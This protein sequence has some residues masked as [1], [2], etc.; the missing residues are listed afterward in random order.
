MRRTK[1]ERE[2]K[3]L[4][5]IDL[6][7]EIIIGLASGEIVADVTK[8]DGKALHAEI[9]RRRQAKRKVRHGGKPPIIQPCAG[10]GS[11]TNARQRWAGCPNCG[12]HTRKK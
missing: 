10:C 5:G 9:A 11:P 2:I 7:E 3:R 6:P 1:I 12:T 4:T 8:L